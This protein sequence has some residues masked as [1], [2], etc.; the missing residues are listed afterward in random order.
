MLTSVV[1]FFA[2][3][4]ALSTLVAPVHTR[5]EILHFFSTFAILVMLTYS[6]IGLLP[7]LVVPVYSTSGA[8]P[9]F[10]YPVFTGSGTFANF[11]STC[12]D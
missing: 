7:T 10:G 12:L 3:H 8:L 9:T 6:G 2:G 1:A 4:G 11:V 5:S